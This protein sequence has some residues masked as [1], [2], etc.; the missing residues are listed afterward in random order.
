MNLDEVIIIFVLVICAFIGGISPII[1]EIIKAKTSTQTGQNN[2]TELLIPPEY[3]H[4]QTPEQS[5]NNPWKW[6]S[7]LAVSFG[8]ISYILIATLLL[9]TPD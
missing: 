4:H 6:V 9:R 5:A 1:I 8:I 2:N 7:I 3:Y